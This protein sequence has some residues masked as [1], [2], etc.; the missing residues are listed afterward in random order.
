MESEHTGLEQPRQ[1]VQRVG[2]GDFAPSGAERQSARRAEDLHICPSCGS[3]LVHPVDWAPASGR[4]WTVELRC[5][6][7]E[8]AGG[9]TYAQEVVDRFDEALDDGTESVLDDLQRLTR[10]NMEDDVEAFLA[11]LHA[12]R[13]LPEDF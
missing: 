2:P 1:E 9:G 12:D 11:A 4:R 10:A 5:P 6:D 3:E 8:W 13:I 7:C